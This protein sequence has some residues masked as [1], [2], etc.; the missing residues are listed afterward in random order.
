M[1]YPTGGAASEPWPPDEAGRQELIRRHVSLVEA[2]VSR[3]MATLPDSVD[4]E[5][6]IS[7]GILGLIQAIDRFQPERG[8]KF[9]TYATSVIRGAVMDE[10]RAQDWAPRSI[11]EKC[12]RLE[13]AM[14]ELE[15]RLGRSPTDDEMAA[16]LR[17][18]LGDYH[19]LLSDASGVM[20]TSFEDLVLGT[21]VA[22]DEAHPPLRASALED[23]EAAVQQKELQ[24][25]LASAIDALPDRERLVIALYYHEEL[26]LREI[27]AVLGVTESR[28]CQVHT[29]AILRLRGR[30]R[31]DLG[32]P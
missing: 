31:A 2:V 6:L 15:A 7:C 20:L 11:R 5:D 30:L 28:V 9:D 12:R 13:R 8:V 24:R 10:L 4:R 1:S 25:L 22:S 27:G 29:Q 21:D 16:E 19:Q 26:T 17:L 18:P 14:A 23:P 3:I 32:L